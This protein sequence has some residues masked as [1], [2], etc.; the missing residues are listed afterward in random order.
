MHAVPIPDPASQQ[1]PQDTGRLSATF[2]KPFKAASTAPAHRSQS[3]ST[4]S[5]PETNHSS[6]FARQKTQTTQSRAI[7]INEMDP[8]LDLPDPK[9]QDLQPRASVASTGSK[10]PSTRIKVGA[11]SRQKT[12]DL[13]FITFC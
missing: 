7:F 8:S 4:S 9:K 6:D 11:V 10:K 3:N 13:D 2:S 1:L 12:R 5:R